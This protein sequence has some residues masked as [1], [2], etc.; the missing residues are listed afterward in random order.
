MRNDARG[1]GGF[2]LI[3]IMVAVTIFV[4]ALAALM[5]L[6]L[7]SVRANASAAEGSQALGIAEDFLEELKLRANGWTT[8]NVPCHIDLADDTWTLPTNDTDCAWPDS[9]WADGK[10]H[11]ADG[12][13]VGE[14]G[15]RKAIYCLHYRRQ[16]TL[17]PD[18]DHT[19]EMVLTVRVAYTADGSETWPD[20]AVETVDAALADGGNARAIILPALIR[21]SPM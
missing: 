21:S 19:G 11:A 17:A 18:I 3:E 12:K 6:L 14:T 8:I 16:Q 10:P 1:E 9:R 4:F 5:T 7:T 15:S 13:G 2:S 20:C